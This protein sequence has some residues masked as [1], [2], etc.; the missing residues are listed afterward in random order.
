M[1]G[2]VSATATHH[3][4][5]L[6]ESVVPH[7][8]ANVSARCFACIR[9]FPPGFS[10]VTD[11]RDP[12][13]AAPVL[14]NRC[15]T[16]LGASDDVKPLPSKPPG[17][18]RE[19]PT[20]NDSSKPGQTSSNNLDKSPGTLVR[21]GGGSVSSGGCPGANQANLSRRILRAQ[22]VNRGEQR[23]RHGGQLSERQ[24]SGALR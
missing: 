16:S 18:H 7:R 20:F 1:V 14:N 2:L 10:F 24:R 5:R 6:A 17:V 12:D 15:R 23:T 4:I 3:A 9:G 19:R 22:V 13:G 11:H 8:F 21:T